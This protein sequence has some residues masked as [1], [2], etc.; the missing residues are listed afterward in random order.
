MPGLGS[1]LG[2]GFVAEELVHG[3]VVDGVDA[4]A[5]EE[6]AHGEADDPEVDEG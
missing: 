4:S 6:G 5:G 2:V 1:S 3:D